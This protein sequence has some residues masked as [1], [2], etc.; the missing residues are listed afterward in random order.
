MKAISFVNSKTIRGIAAAR[1]LFLFLDYDG[2][3]TPIATGPSKAKL[4][5]PTRRL[6]R[7]LAALKDVRVAIVS[8]RSLANLKRYVRIPGLIYAG[9]HGFEAEGRGIFYVH[10]AAMKLR[11]S[12]LRLTRRLRKALAPFRGVLVE[13]K[14]FS[15]SVHYRRVRSAERVREARRVFLNE[16]KALTRTSMVLAGGKKVWE[17]RPTAEWHKGE[18]VLWLMRRVE[19]R[20]RRRYFPV[21]IG[22]DV[23][24]E[25]A[26]R[27]I[28]KRGVGIKV[29]SQKRGKSYARHYLRSPAG[30]VSFL[31]KI[32][33]LRNAA[34]ASDVK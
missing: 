1:Y 2:T 22:D 25:D 27:A 34:G 11:S 24:D 19:R 32:V 8:G 26:F 31:R 9:N 6:I 20:E 21:C 14:T 23:T 10:P 7:E 16:L 15:V 5:G 12:F 33:F 30:V 13:H 28:R 29:H 18:T 3:L 4:S 17:V